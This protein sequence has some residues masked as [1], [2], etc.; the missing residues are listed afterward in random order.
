VDTERKRVEVYAPGH[1]VR[2]LGVEDTLDGGTV[3]PGFRLA[4]KEIFP[5]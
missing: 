5:G 4:I 2:K 1:P 3:L